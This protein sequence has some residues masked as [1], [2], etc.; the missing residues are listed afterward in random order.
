[1]LCYV[2]KLLCDVPGDPICLFIYSNADFDWVLS[3][4]DPNNVIEI[5]GVVLNHL[6]F[7]DDIDKAYS[8]E[9]LWER[10]AQSID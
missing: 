4:V 8:P 9:H 3:T 2:I 5:Q 1:M 10:T 7:A 6:A